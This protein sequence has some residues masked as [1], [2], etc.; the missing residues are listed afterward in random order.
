[1]GEGP[2]L[3]FDETLISPELE[4]PHHKLFLYLIIHIIYSKPPFPLT[5]TG[6][7]RLSETVCW[8]TGE[9]TVGVFP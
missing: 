1:M 9:R 8:A 3:P 5:H 2:P 6:E 4:L 7:Q